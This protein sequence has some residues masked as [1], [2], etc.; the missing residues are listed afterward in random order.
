MGGKCGW[1]SRD[2]EISREKSP[3]VSSFRSKFTCAVV[4]RGEERRG[5]ERRGEERRG[6]EE[7]SIFVAGSISR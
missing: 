4:R 2:G 1:E 6:G 7:S 3:L 5:E